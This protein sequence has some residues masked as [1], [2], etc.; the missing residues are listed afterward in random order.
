[1]PPFSLTR[2]AK[3]S[4]LLTGG[5]TQGIGFN[6]VPDWDIYKNDDWGKR[7]EV[8]RRLVNL[9]GRWIV[10]RRARRRLAAI[11]VRSGGI[12]LPRFTLDGALSL[13]I[14]GKSGLAR[15]VFFLH[16]RFFED[17]GKRA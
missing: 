12:F 5:G 15:F 2:F 11:Q 14:T 9:V 17:R 10:R 4:V 7:R 8:L 3:A 6:H 16:R 13:Q 1:M